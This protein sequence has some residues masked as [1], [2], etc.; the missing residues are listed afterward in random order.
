[1]SWHINVSVGTHTG[2]VRGRNED[3]A[4][5]LSGQQLLRSELDG[6][7][8]VLTSSAPV[9][10]VVADGMGGHPCGDL[11]SR[12]AVDHLLGESPISADELIVAVHEAN[13]VLY[14]SMDDESRYMGTTIAAVLVDRDDVVSVV[15]V[16]DSPVYEFVDG[17]L[18]ELTTGDSLS[19]DD[20]PF[21]LQAGTMTQALGGG[22]EYEEIEPHVHEDDIA[23][24]RRL[25][26][27]SDGLSNFVHPAEIIEVLTLWRG[28]DAVTALID[29]ALSAGAPDN[30][31]VV[32]MELT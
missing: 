17:G 30:V 9:L 28:G 10:A 11:A 24:A 31:T 12:L 26:L 16:G 27:C 6:E 29:R 32:L 19:P 13:R 18:V 14:S 21:G 20:D 1:M 2:L 25:L 22:G 7:V 15:N 8:Q 3:R 4:G 23:G 5:L